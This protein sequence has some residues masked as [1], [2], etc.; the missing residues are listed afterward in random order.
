MSSGALQVTIRSLLGT[1]VIIAGNVVVVMSAPK[2]TAMSRTDARS[3]SLKWARKRAERDGSTP[4]LK[5]FLKDDIRQGSFLPTGV[6]YT[7]HDLAG[8]FD[9]RYGTFIA[10]MAAG[11]ALCESVCAGGRAMRNVVFEFSGPSDR[12]WD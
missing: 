3:V 8:R 1:A 11:Y 9:L 10:A 4:K 5:S 6:R 12:M 2:A 7:L